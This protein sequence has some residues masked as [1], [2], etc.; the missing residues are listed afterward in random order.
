[1][2]RGSRGSYFHVEVD[3]SS[4]EG[5]RSAAAAAVA[6]ACGLERYQGYAFFPPGWPG[7]PGSPCDLSRARRVHFFFV[8]RS[9]R[10]L[11]CNDLDF[12]GTAPI[13]LS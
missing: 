9:F 7:W 1:M 2:R 3:Y 12:F 11:G 10:E 8:F 13:F 5:D 6:A 4:E